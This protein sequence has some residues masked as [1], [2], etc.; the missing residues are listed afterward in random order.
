MKK[1]LLVAS[2][3][4]AVALAACNKSNDQAAAPASDAAAASAP[5]ARSFGLGYG[6]FGCRCCCERCCCFGYGCCFGRRRCCF[7]RRRCCFGSCSGFGRKPVSCRIGLASGRKLHRE[8]VAIS[9]AV[10]QNATDSHPWRFA[11]CAPFYDD[12]GGTF[13][14]DGSPKR[15]RVLFEELAHHVDFARALERRQALPDA[16][17]IRFV[18]ETRVA[19]H[20]HAAIRLRAN[21]PARALLQRDHR[22]RQLMH[23]ERAQALSSSARRAAPRAPDRR[24]ARTAACRSRRATAR[25]RARR[26]LPRSSDCPRESRC[27]RRGNGRATRC[28]SRRPARAADSPSRAASIVSR[29]RI[30]MRSTA[31]SVVHSTNTPPPDASIAGNAASNTASVNCGDDGCGRLRGTYSKPLRRIVEGARQRHRAARVQAHLRGVVREVAAHRKRR[32]REDPRARHAG[33]LLR[34][35]RRDRQRR[36][37]QLHGMREHFDPAHHF[38]RIRAFA[39]CLRGVLVRRRPRVR[40]DVGGVVQPASTPCNSR[41]RRTSACSDSARSA[42]ADSA[43][44]SASRCV[45]ERFERFEER[46]IVGQLAERQAHRIFLER[47][48]HVARRA[49]QRGAELGPVGRRRARGPDLRRPNRARVRGTASSRA[50]RRRRASRFRATDAL[51]RR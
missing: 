8:I 5:A 47:E 39:A 44:A 21:Q 12:D 17:A 6:C 37:V 10:K 36:L 50:S 26:R 38:V 23:G 40:V 35:D 31:R 22:L 32:R 7:G 43:A 34:E 33:A 45:F 41:A 25:R 42:C 48:P 14:T 27:R 46:M 28:G 16:P 15:R 51:R 9:R 18:D 20:Q 19:D 1:S 4:A 3:L 2:L 24:A 13:G 11:I 30:E 29:R 49:L